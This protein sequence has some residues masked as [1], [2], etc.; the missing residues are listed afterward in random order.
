MCEQCTADTE[1]FGEVVPSWRLCRARKTGN[2]MKAGDWGLVDFDNPDFYWKSTPVLDPTFE[3]DAAYDDPAQDEAI[4][5]FLEVADELDACFKC[6]P[7]TGYALVTACLEAGWDRKKHGCR[8]EC[9]LVHRMALL[10][11]KA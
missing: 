2:F 3:N 9:F 11:Q 1:D 7:L 6:Y 4:E 5:N 8:L 10:L